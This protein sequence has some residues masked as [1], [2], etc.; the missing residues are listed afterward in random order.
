MFSIYINHIKTFKKI[1]CSYKYKPCL[2]LKSGVNYI[3]LR[4]RVR[5]CWTY[6]SPQ[7]QKVKKVTAIKIL[8]IVT[9]FL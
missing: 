3:R 7:N 6:I 9:L 5:E 8:D 1:N 2:K 4:V